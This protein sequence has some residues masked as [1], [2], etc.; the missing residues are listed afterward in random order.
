MWAMCLKQH[1]SGGE[2]GGATYVDERVAALVQREIQE[3]DRVG[4][5]QIQELKATIGIA[6][7]PNYACHR[8]F[9]QA[10]KEYLE[11]QQDVEDMELAY[12]GGKIWIYPF[13]C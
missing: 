1:I 4:E 10:R 3:M 12:N 2:K 7:Y 9:V 5:E 8:E 11:Y 13:K 6:N